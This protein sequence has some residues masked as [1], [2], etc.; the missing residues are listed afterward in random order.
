MSVVVRVF[1]AAPLSPPILDLP[2]ELLL[3]IIDSLP[4]VEAACLAL[5]C[6]KLYI[7]N[8]KCWGSLRVRFSK[9]DPTRE[10]FKDPTRHSRHPLHGSKWIVASLNERLQER[11]RLL[12]L[13]QRDS[14]KHR[15]CNDCQTLHWESTTSKGGPNDE[16]VIPKSLELSGRKIQPGGC[17]DLRWNEFFLMDI[18]GIMKRQ[19]DGLGF[20]RPPCLLRRLGKWEP[21]TLIQEN[22]HFCHPQNMQHHIAWVKLSM[23]PF[24]VKDS[25]VLHRIQ[26]ICIPRGELGMGRFLRC[27]PSVY[28][29]DGLYICE[30]HSTRGVLL[31]LQY[32]NI[33]WRKADRTS[34]FDGIEVHRCSHCTTEYRYSAVE[35]SRHSERFPTLEIIVDIWENIGNGHDHTPERGFN[36]GYTHNRLYIRDVMEMTRDYARYGNKVFSTRPSET[37]LATRDLLGI[38]QETRVLESYDDHI[39]TNWWSELSSST[40]SNLFSKLRVA[41]GI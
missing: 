4:A 36:L 34:P 26:R 11:Y 32:R 33:L 21:T 31:Q 12:T 20:G 22:E 10:T 13:L 17:F 16:D 9:Q 8:Q 23:E 14:A 35:H 7:F 15:L 40:I 24:I 2:P 1:V 37:G 39:S 41:L 18:E 38:I 29:F 6:R 3:K 25:L 5:S 30:Y 19:L 27:G 28:A